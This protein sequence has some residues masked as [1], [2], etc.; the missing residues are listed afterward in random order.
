MCLLAPLCPTPPVTPE[1]GQKEFVPKVF[2]LEPIESCAIDGET[3][4]YKCHSFMN[5]YI[6]AASFGRN[7][8]NL[9]KLC[10]GEKPDDRSE[11][12]QNCLDTVE[13]LQFARG[14]CHGQDS[15]SLAVSPTLASL[16]ASCDGLRREARV[17]H[18]CGELTYTY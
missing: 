18:I 7:A 10:D 15:C 3:I 4:D 11:A 6:P 9:K 12:T 2:E 5:V 8:S 17:G 1:E 14:S 13:V 16:D